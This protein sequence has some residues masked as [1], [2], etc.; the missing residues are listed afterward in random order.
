MIR[1][2]IQHNTTQEGSTV[3]LTATYFLRD[4]HNPRFHLDILEH[5]LWNQKVSELARLWFLM[6]RQ[7]NESDANAEILEKYEGVD[8]TV[9]ELLPGDP[10]ALRFKHENP[11][12]IAAL[13]ERVR[14][15]TAMIIEDA[16]YEDYLSETKDLYLPINDPGVAPSGK[17]LP[18]IK[19]EARK[20]ITDRN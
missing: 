14:R 20:K 17:A 2:T 6:H 3:F 4:H 5:R 18:E 11:V 8:C 13:D 19:P 16:V 9:R 1:L 7:G 15:A 12:V 10:G